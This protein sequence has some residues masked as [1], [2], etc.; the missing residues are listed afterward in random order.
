MVAAC[1]DYQ[2]AGLVRQGFSRRTPARDRASAGAA[3]PLVRARHRQSLG[4]RAAG[5]RPLGALWLT[6][7]NRTAPDLPTDLAFTDTEVRLLE[8]L[9]P[10]DER[11]KDKTLEDFPIRLAKL[12]GYLGRAQDAP[13]GDMVF[14]RG[15]ARLTDIRLGFCL[16]RDVG[17]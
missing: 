4:G 1:S 3:R 11:S 15:M 12:G 2:E 6:M 8:S 17:N 13:P 5:T 16:A 9:V 10:H 7:L 14:R